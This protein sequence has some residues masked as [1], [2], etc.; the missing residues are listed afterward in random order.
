MKWTQRRV[1]VMAQ[2]TDPERPKI[3]V[4]GLMNRLVGVHQT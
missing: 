3:E 1:L 2:P 4:V